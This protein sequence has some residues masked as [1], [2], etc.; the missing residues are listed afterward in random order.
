LGDHSGVVV[1]CAVEGELDILEKVEESFALG[2]IDLVET[3]VIFYMAA[4]EGQLHQFHGKPKA[5]SIVEEAGAVAVEVG[6]K[7]VVQFLTVESGLEVDMGNQL[8]AVVE[9]A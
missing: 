6:N 3:L 7:A 8:L 4:V 1:A 2:C 5:E 9:Q